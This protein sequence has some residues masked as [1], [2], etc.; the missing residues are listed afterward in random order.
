MSFTLGCVLVRASQWADAFDGVINYRRYLM[1]Q[2]NL[3]VRAEI[4]ANHLIRNSGAF[5]DLALSESARHSVYRGLLRLQ[6]K[7]ALRAF[8][9][10]IR[11]EKLDATRDPH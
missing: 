7:L 1:K 3:P 8:G 9:I 6:A 10:V 11:K 2:F 5:R 4:K